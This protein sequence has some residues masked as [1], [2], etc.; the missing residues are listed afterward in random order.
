[1]NIS[2]RCQVYTLDKPSDTFQGW[3]SFLLKRKKIL[4]FLILF[5]S[6]G[7]ASWASVWTGDLEGEIS[8]LAGGIYGTLSWSDLTF[9]WSVSQSGS[10]WTYVY[11]LSDPY[12]KQ[13]KELSHLII[14]VPDSFSVTDI[15]PGT[16]PF[17][18]GDGLATY[19]GNN[20]SNP[21]MPGTITGIKWGT[22]EEGVGPWVENNSGSIMS[23]T[24]TLVSDKPPMPGNF[25]AK[26][27]KEGGEPVYAWSGTSTE[28]GYNIPVPDPPSGTTAPEPMTL[29]LYGFG[30]AG[31][32]IYRHLRRRKKKEGT[33]LTELN[34]SDTKCAQAPSLYS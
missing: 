9:S 17:Y 34:N 6:L 30:F 20:P 23:Y 32:G 33:L 26:D 13:V 11:T 25:Y 19:S 21:N 16:T 14:Q 27:G 28:F 15:K 31:A 29:T 4:L 10:V 2:Q 7:S 18:D 1:M 12:S 8:G 5:L 22:D 24:I 3:Y